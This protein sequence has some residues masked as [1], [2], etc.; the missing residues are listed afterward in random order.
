M[1]ENICL[2]KQKAKKSSQARILVYDSINIQFR[3]NN[4]QVIEVSSA[5]IGGLQG[6]MG[7]LL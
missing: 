7:A 3:T 6:G 1:L 4:Q 2:K 5:G